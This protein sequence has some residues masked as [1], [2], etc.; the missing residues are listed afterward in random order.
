MP[1]CHFWFFDKDAEKDDCYGN[2][3]YQLRQKVSKVMR[4]AW[5]W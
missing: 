4:K 2:S 5:Q 1:G 3:I